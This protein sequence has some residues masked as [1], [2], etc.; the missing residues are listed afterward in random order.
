MIEATEIR[1]KYFSALNG[2]KINGVEI[3]VFDEIATSSATIAG[4]ECYIVLQNQQSYPSAVQGLSCDKATH[5][6]TLRIVTR[7]AKDSG[8][9]LSEQIAKE[10]D[11]R[12]REN[13]DANKLGINRITLSLS[14]SIIETNDNN[15]IAYTH[16]LIYQN[17]INNKI[18]G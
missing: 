4:A 12:I 17:Y 6:I 18:G 7:Y 5:D 9:K 3:P 11:A 8:K 14:N 15:A 2:I 16:I 1:T 13:R 10:V